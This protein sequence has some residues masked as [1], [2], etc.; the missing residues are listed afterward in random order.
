MPRSRDVERVL[1][2]YDVVAIGG[3][4]KGYC[5]EDTRKA[6]ENILEDTEIVSDERFLY[7]L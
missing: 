1:A 3:S 2:G 4:N 5:P 7:S 6:I